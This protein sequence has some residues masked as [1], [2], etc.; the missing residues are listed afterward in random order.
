MPMIPANG[1]T[2][3]VIQAGTGPDVVMLHGL[4]GNLAVWHLKMVPMMVLVQ[5]L[6]VH[7]FLLLKKCWNFY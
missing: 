7:P 6:L 4:S 1:V 3:H 2:F 5:P